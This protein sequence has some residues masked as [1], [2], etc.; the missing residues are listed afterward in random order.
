MN[1]NERPLYR[2]DGVYGL[3]ADA[4]V[5]DQASGEL[6]FISLWGRDTA[7]QEFLA[8]LSLPPGQGGFSAFNLTGTGQ[9]G[10]VL[11]RVSNPGQMAKLGGRMPSSGLF[12]E[13][14]Q[15]WIYTPLAL[16]LDYAGRRALRILRADT[17]GP[18]QADEAFEAEAAWSLLKEVS[19]LPL[20]DGWRQ[21]VVQAAFGR[22]WI[23][24]HQGIAANALEI[25]LGDPDYETVISGLIKGGILRPPGDTLPPSS[26]DRGQGEPESP[27]PSGRKRLTSEQLDS[28]LFQFSGTENWYRHWLA[29]AMLYTDGV[30]SFAEHGGQEGAYWFLDVVAT[31]FFPLLRKEA[32]LHIVLSVKDRK[33]TIRVDDGNDHALREKPIEFTDMQEG[34]WRFYLTD[35]VLLLPGEY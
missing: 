12:G 21:A 4:A 5:W 33:A 15:T 14:A 17:D 3:F 7:L 10:K 22:G 11:V 8:R 26:N 32:F 6:F 24:R 31:E 20:L 34:D 27:P 23:K 2:V 30:K 29:K 25:D 19:H 18:D 16:S 9:E 13:V 28:H 35:N 1:P